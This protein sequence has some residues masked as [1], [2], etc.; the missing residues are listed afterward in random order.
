MARVFY[1]S[2]KYP[3]FKDQE[4]LWDVIQER[5]GEFI[6]KCV[7]RGIPE[8][9]AEYAIKY[10]FERIKELKILGSYYLLNHVFSITRMSREYVKTAESVN[11]TALKYILGFIL[12]INDYINDFEENYKHYDFVYKNEQNDFSENDRYDSILREIFE[13]REIA[14]KLDLKIKRPQ[15]TE[16]DIHGEL[17]KYYMCAENKYIIFQELYDE[18]IE[19]YQKI[20]ADYEENHIDEYDEDLN[21]D[22]NDIFDDDYDFEKE[23]YMDAKASLESLVD[24]Y[25]QERTKC[26]ERYVSKAINFTD[27]IIRYWYVDEHCDESEEAYIDELLDKCDEIDSKLKDILVGDLERYAKLVS[28]DIERV[29]MDIELISHCVED[30]VD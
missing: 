17:H 8:D 2:S 3:I 24:D 11:Q 28:Q 10:E 5:K 6:C 14:F 21:N 12:N 25:E 30:K 22:E 1:D 20:I 7:E 13:K 27:I 18:D 26:L 23:E 4:S 9:V 29:K 15:N 16:L 19:Y